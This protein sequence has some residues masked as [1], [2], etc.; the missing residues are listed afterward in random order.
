MPI[1]GIPASGCVA[2]DEELSDDVLD[3]YREVHLFADYI[4]RAEARPQITD[5]YAI[6]R[7]VSCEQLAQLVFTGLVVKVPK[8]E[9]LHVDA[10]S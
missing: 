9:V 10:L 7:T 4:E 2:Q 3:R 8:E 6:D 1:A 5:T